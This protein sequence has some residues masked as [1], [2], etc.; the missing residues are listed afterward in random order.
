MLTFRGGRS[1]ALLLI[2]C[3]PALG[4]GS[5]QTV[6]VGEGVSFELPPGLVEQATRPPFL[7]MWT[8]PTEEVSMF[9]VAVRTSQ[10]EAVK[11]FED[12]PGVGRSMAAGAGEKL[13]KR[14]GEQLGAPCSYTGTPMARDAGR[15]LMRV[16]VDVTCRTSPEPTVLR[17]QMLAILTRTSEVV[18]RVDAL[19]GAYPAGESIASAV[20]A[21]LRVAP[22]HRIAVA[23]AQSQSEPLSERGGSPVTGGAGFHLTDYGRMRTPYLIGGLV[24]G[25]FAA[26]LIGGVL[27]A[28]LLKLRVPPVPAVIGAQLLLIVLGV[29]GDSH[30]GAWELDWVGRG[31][32]AI[33]A[34][35]F[36][37]RWARRRWEKKHDPAVHAA[38]VPPV[39]ERR[40]P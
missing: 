2:L 4:Y 24:G 19:K 11:E 7:K 27:T 21:S 40:E 33:V 20:W 35:H 15:Y 3:V 16:A 39:R 36:L 28:L 5:T 8:G 6:D 9:A 38:P 14:L 26:F 25:L 34:G 10:E 32:S 18:V 23:V 1:L 29:W 30:D 31:V 17:A 37:M 22:E 12:W 13:T